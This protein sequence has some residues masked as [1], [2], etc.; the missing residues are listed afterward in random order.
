MLEKLNSYIWGKGLIMLILLTG[1]IYTVKT[2]FVQLRM[3]PYIFKRLRLSKN[4]RSQ[5]GIFCMSLG[6]AMGTGNITG[7]ASAIKIGGAGAVFWMWISAFMGMALVY[8]ENSLSAK[9]SFKSICGPMAYIR[10][11][12]GSRLLTVVFAICCLLAS[13][14]MGGMVQINEM[15][16]NIRKCAD[17]PVFQMFIGLFIIIFLSIGGGS[18]R[19][20]SIAQF[21]LPLATIVYSL[22]CVA[23][24]ISS[25]ISFYGAFSRI[26][27]EALGIKQIFG[28]VSGY[29]IS[30]VVSVG[31]RRGIFS[32]E[33]GLGSSPILHSSAENSMSA[34]TQGMCSMFEVFID[35]FLCCT[36]TAV[37]LLAT[38][39][40]TI[41]SSF[42]PVIGG[43]TEIIL[44]VLMSVFAFCTVIGW[45]YCGLRAFR[46]VF[47]GGS[48][49]FFV[50]FSAVGAS[51][52]VL[53]TDE[54]W[55]LSDIF[56]GLMAFVNIFA[57]L[58]LVKDIQKE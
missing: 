12:T 27:T 1:A 52:A 31:I 33:A 43:S 23:A 15:A 28:G 55:V 9:Y 3:I 18:R 8:A 51:G 22:L 38:G 57:L 44:A 49:I 19:I 29:S 41:Y 54:I 50:L 34:E 45:S 4:K 7:V 6:T 48:M 36:L 26:F 25:K 40:Q 30:K 5:F 11:G 32:N 16:N 46:Y 2:G 14:G 58:Y 20:S 47:G 35:T 10:F 37:T 53:K 39:S 21:L 24:I 17:I 56:N 42:L 13:F